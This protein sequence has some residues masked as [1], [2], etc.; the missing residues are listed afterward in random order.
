M[1]L[2]SH[3][4]PRALWVEGR[5]ELSFVLLSPCSPHSSWWELQRQRSVWSRGMVRQMTCLTD[6]QCKQK[7]GHSKF[8]PMDTLCTKLKTNSSFTS[9]ILSEAGFFLARSSPAS[10]SHGHL[11]AVCLYFHGIGHSTCHGETSIGHNT[12]MVF[13]LLFRKIMFVV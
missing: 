12:K 8:A 9:K 4:S 1:W 10:C 5:G 2:F 7:A 3:F 11:T 13:Q 6:L